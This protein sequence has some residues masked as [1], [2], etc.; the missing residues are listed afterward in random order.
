A[1]ADVDVSDSLADDGVVDES[2]SASE[3]DER[4]N[5]ATAASATA[6]ADGDAFVHEHGDGA[7]PTVVHLTYAVGVRDAD[8]G[9]EDFVETAGTVHLPQRPH[10]DTRGLE[11]DDEHGD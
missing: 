5:S 3:V 4:T 11:V 9:E 2:A 1:A 7:P 8:V 10:L 6:G